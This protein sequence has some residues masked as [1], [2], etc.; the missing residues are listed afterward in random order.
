MNLTPASLKTLRRKGFKET[1]KYFSQSSSPLCVF[2]S[3]RETSPAFSPP[4]Q[5]AN[6]CQ[7]HRQRTVRLS[8]FCLGTGNR[9]KASPVG[10][11][12]SPA[13]DRRISYFRQRGN[14][15]V[16]RTLTLDLCSKGRWGYSPGLVIPARLSQS[17]LTSQ[18]SFFPHVRL[19]LSNPN[20]EI[21]HS[22]FGLGFYAGDRFGFRRWCRLRRH[23][24]NP[25]PEVES[26]R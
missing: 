18:L 17:Y 1:M 3:L 4:R 23:A 13:F 19:F 26:S 2:A 21:T 15:G 14:L 10:G 11:P 25:R 7:F 5:K 9:R 12:F 22:I 16:G 6:S 8:N 24:P 20:Y